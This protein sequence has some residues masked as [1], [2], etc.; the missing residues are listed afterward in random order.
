MA[1]LKK[2]TPKLALAWLFGAA[3]FVLA[4]PTSLSFAVGAAPVTLGAALRLWACGHLEKN[5]KLTTSGPYA[6]VQN[7]L[8]LGTFLI[9]LGFCVMARNLYV[10][11]GGALLFFAYYIPFKRQREGDRLRALF[12]EAYDDYA[13]SVPALFPIRIAPYPMRSGDRFMP[14]LIIE[15]SEHGTTLAVLCGVVLMALRVAFPDVLRLG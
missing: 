13:R 1:W 15:N 12:G 3:I 9:M 2:P 4:R 7:P 11:L 10:L 8:Y 14:S 6:F 5:K